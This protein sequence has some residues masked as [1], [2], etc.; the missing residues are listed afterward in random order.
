MGKKVKLE[1]FGICFAGWA[2]SDTLSN[3]KEILV[4]PLMDGA[5][6]EKKISISLMG[7]NEA[8]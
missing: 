8:T 2:L 7:Y 4:Y 3:S 6:R 1:D 5:Y